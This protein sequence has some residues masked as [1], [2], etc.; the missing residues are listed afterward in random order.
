M[1]KARDIMI[2][3]I[4][5]LIILLLGY[6]SY[7]FLLSQVKEKQ[8][9]E[10]E[11]GPIKNKEVREIY[12]WMK[13]SLDSNTICLGWFYQNPFQ[14]HTLHDRVS[15]VLLHYGDSQKK[16][17]DSTF[18][19]SLEENRELLSNYQYYVSGDTIR[20]GMKKIF[21]EAI[22]YFD[23]QAEYLSWYYQSDI[24]MFLLKEKTEN[25]LPITYHQEV[26]QYEQKDGKIM[27]T[28]AKAEFS[29]SKQKIYRYYYK[30]ESLVYDSYTE[31]FDFT[32]DNV[33][34]FPQVQY[35][36]QQKDGHYYLEDIINL[37]YFEDYEQCN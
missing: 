22:E 9:E 16:E 34:Q 26:I 29:E 21:N 27:V 32:K 37:N 17:I 23:D 25:L 2:I 19:S 14:N 31:E 8:E 7:S 33:E 15:L 11:I 35:V 18:L 5:I 13:P 24:D 1:S 12:E 30:P 28:V 10:K 20:D 36:F 6:G 3:L 4:L